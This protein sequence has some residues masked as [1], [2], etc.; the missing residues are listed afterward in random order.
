MDLRVGRMT[1]PIEDNATPH[2]FDK[3]KRVSFGKYSSGCESLS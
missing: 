1:T 2:V 3:V